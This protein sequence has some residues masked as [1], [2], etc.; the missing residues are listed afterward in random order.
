MLHPNGPHVHSLRR[1]GG[2]VK[3]KGVYHAGS[4]DFAL[5]VDDLGAGVVIICGHGVV[6][7]ACTFA[8][9]QTAA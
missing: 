8:D 9:C 6:P 4:A 2:Y 5:Q 7:C 3:G 1:R